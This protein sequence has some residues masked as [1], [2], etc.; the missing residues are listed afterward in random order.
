MKDTAPDK[1]SSNEYV[2]NSEEKS[3]VSKD[4][5]NKRDT[6]SDEVALNE[7]A[8]LCTDRSSETS[9]DGVMKTAPDR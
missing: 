5:E 8:Y 3:E 6:A 2:H 9:E 4:E 7:F 1:K